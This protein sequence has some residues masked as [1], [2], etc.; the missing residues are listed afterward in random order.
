MTDFPNFDSK[1]FRPPQEWWEGDTEACPDPAWF[2]DY[3]EGTLSPAQAEDCRRRLAEDAELY[4]RYQG[5]LQVKERMKE[6][7]AKEGM[8]DLRARIL[9]GLEGVPHAEGVPRS[10]GSSARVLAFVASISIA[11]AALLFFF[12]LMRSEHRDLPLEIGKAPSLDTV[13]DN[14]DRIPVLNE[15]EEESEDSGPASGNPSN[16]VPSKIQNAHEGRDAGRGRE[17]RMARLAKSPK[18]GEPR[19]EELKRGKKRGATAQGLRG[20]NPR[21]S[22]VGASRAS[23]GNALKA[24]VAEEGRLETAKRSQS[25]KR[26][27]ARRESNPLPPSNKTLPKVTLLEFVFS[28]R[29]SENKVRG[30]LSKL[31][32][33]LFMGGR[34]FDRLDKKSDQKKGEGLYRIALTGEELLVFVEKM[35]ALGG[36]LQ[37]KQIAPPLVVTKWARGRE[38]TGTDDFALGRRPVPE[39]KGGRKRNSSPPKAMELGSSKRGVAKTPSEPKG[40]ARANQKKRKTRKDQEGLGFPSSPSPRTSSRKKAKAKKQVFYIRLRFSK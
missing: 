36:V 13:G 35:K 32:P 27:L 18:K 26:G 34:A 22:E 37:E 40:Q 14:K 25:R 8:G 12:V 23:K 39:K 19:D 30:E 24:V 2:L 7:G 33:S 29:G 3:S 31:V 11:A 6:L 17:K 20:G 28:G 16:K 9:A 4:R 10:G 5:Y 38:N 1:P 21:G 15:V